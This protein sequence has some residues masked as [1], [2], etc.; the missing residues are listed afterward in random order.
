[1]RAGAIPGISCSCEV[2]YCAF[3]A[4]R[5]DCSSTRVNCSISNA[6]Y[7]KN[8]YNT[9]N[10]KGGRGALRVNLG[11]NWSVTPT[12]MGQSVDAEGFFGFDPA[13]GD[14]QV[15]HFG[16]E[17]SQDSWLQAALTVE[18]K[19]SDF[20][21]VYAGAFMKRTTHAIA[22]YSDYSLFYD[23]L[24]GSGSYWQGNNGTPII[25]CTPPM[26]ASSLAS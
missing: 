9:V 21:M 18:G 7:V 22:D 24:Y 26:R 5:R 10:T 11:D 6:A 8:H 3:C 23:R 19:V 20:D 14:L 2:R 1:M 13:I 15:T 17:S 25:V 4:R 12:V 16:P